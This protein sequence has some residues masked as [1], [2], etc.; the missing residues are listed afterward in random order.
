MEA[1]MQEDHEFVEIPQN[2]P[3]PNLNRVSY[4][5]SDEVSISEWVVIM[6]IMCV[7][8]VNIVMLCVWAFDSSTKASK[9]NWAKASLIFVGISVV[10][11]ILFA[12]AFGSIFASMMGGAANPGSFY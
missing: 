2:N 7:P 12:I 11:G 3:Q 6:L 8:I 9:A 1:F 10:L 5:S 4:M